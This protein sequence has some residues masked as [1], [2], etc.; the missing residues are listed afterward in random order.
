[1]KKVVYVYRLTDAL[2]QQDVCF[3]TDPAD[4]GCLAGY[5]ANDR[6]WEFE[7]VVFYAQDWAAQHGFQL[8]SARME[9]DIPD[10][11]FMAHPLGTPLQQ[12]I[13]H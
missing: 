8:E 12:A 9:I 13:H 10:E 6:Y 7:D 1:M 11:I 4:R 2:G 5:D 3:A